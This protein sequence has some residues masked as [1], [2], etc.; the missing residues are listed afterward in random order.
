MR[1][2]KSVV[3]AIRYRHDLYRDAG[4]AAQSSG[5]LSCFVFCHSLLI[6]TENGAAQQIICTSSV[7]QAEAAITAIPAA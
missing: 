4:T 2:K 6:R 5:A 7:S 1:P 3:H